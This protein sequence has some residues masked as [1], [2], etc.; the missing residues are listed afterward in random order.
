MSPRDFDGRSDLLPRSFSDFSLRSRVLDAEGVGLEA[1]SVAITGAG[2]I[3]VASVRLRATVNPFDS[4][5][6]VSW[7]AVMVAGAADCGK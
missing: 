6:S 4:V 3:G 2:A 7:V 1:E 5:L